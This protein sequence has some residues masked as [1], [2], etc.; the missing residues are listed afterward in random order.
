M[1]KE[2]R[3]KS[4]MSVINKELHKF[5]KKNEN[6]TDISSNFQ[7]LKKTLRGKNNIFFLINDYNQEILQHYDN[8]YQTK[9]NYDLFIKSIESKKYF[10]ENLNIN[11]NLF[12]IPDKSITL[13]EY[14][15]FESI[16]PNRHTNNLKGYLYDLHE[17]IT[18][19]DTLSNDTHLSEKSSPKIVSYILSK[20]YNK[21]CSYFK[22]KLVE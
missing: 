16:S 11:Y 22:R 19:E 17:I 1:L 13:R 15:P 5:F 9:L 20:M 8:T 18:E 6:G 2:K 4:K 21:P 12:I 14:L 7:G 10:L 3:K